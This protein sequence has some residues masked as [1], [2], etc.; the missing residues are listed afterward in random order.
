MSKRETLEKKI[1]IESL[2]D[3]EVKDR[4]LL[5]A[6]RDAERGGTSPYRSYTGKIAAASKRIEQLRRYWHEIN[7]AD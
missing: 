2:I 6:Y 7:R 4:L 1:H 3:K 5:F